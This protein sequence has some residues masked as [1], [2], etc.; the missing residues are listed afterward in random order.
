VIDYGDYR[1]VDGEQAPF[2]TDGLGATTIVVQRIRFN[3]A[4]PDGAFA[5][6]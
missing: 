5:A 4:V 1:A 2:W 6:R 3:E